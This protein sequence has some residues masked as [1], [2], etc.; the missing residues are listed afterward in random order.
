MTEFSE[1][2]AAVIAAIPPGKVL[3]YGQAAALAGNPKAARQ[4][5]R[6]LN[7][8]AGRLGL[9]WHRLVNREGRIALP[10]GGGF[11]LQKA[12]LEAEG[13]PIDDSGRIAC[14]D[15]PAFDRYRWEVSDVSD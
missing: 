7:S 8:S 10:A 4:V 5:V 2:L 6:F 14:E 9:P 1:R 3:A 15:G 11:E 13:V 12:L